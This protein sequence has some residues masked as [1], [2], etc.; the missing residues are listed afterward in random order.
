V[1]KVERIL[2]RLDASGEAKDMDVPGFGLH[3]MTGDRKGLLSLLPSDVQR[4]LPDEPSR[5]L[6]G[7]KED[8][9]LALGSVRLGWATVIPGGPG[10]RAK[11]VCGCAA[12]A[13]RRQCRPP[14]VSVSPSVSD[15]KK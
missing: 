10:L 12:S 15:A 11:A 8:P 4:P 7:E 5:S 6:Q 3:A 1:A 13:S 9:M 14:S 2:A